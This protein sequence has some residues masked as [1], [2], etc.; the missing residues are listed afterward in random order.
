MDFEDRTMGR[1]AFAQLMLALLCGCGNWAANSGQARR[2][3]T[4]SL[5]EARSGFVTNL[6]QRTSAG[7]RLP[8]PPPELF[9]IVQF[10]SEL[11]K[12]GAYLTPDP[13]DGKKHPAIIWITGGDCSTIDEGVWQDAP[14]SNDQ[15]ARQYREA[16]IVMMFPTLRGGNENPGVHEGFFGEIDDVISAAE[17]L[18]TQDYVDP[19]R[20]YLGGHSSGATMAL[21]AAECS[22]EFRAVFSFGPVNDLRK[23]P[24]SFKILFMPFDT[25][26]PRELELRTPALWLHSIKRPVFVFAGT[27]R[28]GALGEIQTMSR[29]TSNPEVH[30]FTVKGA[31][32]FN[33]LAPLNRLVA[34][35]ILDDSGSECSIAF[36]ADELN[37]PFASP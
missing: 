11:G 15:T 19:E 27:V 6:V 31:D 2:T 21:L 32:H 28:D 22:E 16:G 5:T 30:F 35:K 10:D 20:I 9:R 1:I 34:Q 26:D 36:T 33:I 7:Q 18:S 25:S 37:K 4:E 3:P 8:E 23:V 14:I 24:E 17:Y 29:S 13:M 12:L